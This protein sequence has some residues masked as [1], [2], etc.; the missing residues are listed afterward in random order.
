[1]TVSSEQLVVSSENKLSVI[2]HDQI[3]Y[4]DTANC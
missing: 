3:D 1:M 4:N 2:F